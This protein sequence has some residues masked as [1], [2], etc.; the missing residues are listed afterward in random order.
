ML[1]FVHDVVV[2][3]DA[4]H[5]DFGRCLQNLVA[6]EVILVDGDVAVQGEFEDV[7]EQVEALAL[8]LHGVIESGV[9]LVVQ[10]YLAVDIAAPY[11]V[12]GHVERCGVLQAHALRHATLLRGVLLLSLLLCLL[13]APLLWL[14]QHRQR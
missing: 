7:G 14:G 10:V 6:V 9:L 12:L 2:V 13:G 8:R 3:Q 11:H 4:L 1:L 5:V